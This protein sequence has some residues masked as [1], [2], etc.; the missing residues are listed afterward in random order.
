MILKNKNEK[1][2]ER[3]KREKVV[4]KEDPLPEKV[5]QLQEAILSYATEN[6]L[7]NVI[8]KIGEVGPQDIGKVIGLFN[9]DIVTDF[10]KDYESVLKE[11][12][13]KEVKAITKSIGRATVPMV[14]E[15]CMK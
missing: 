2:A 9:K 4:K 6:R 15:R 8:S 3:I 13:K 7:N 10:F 12:E 1:W 5:I 14:K 11:L